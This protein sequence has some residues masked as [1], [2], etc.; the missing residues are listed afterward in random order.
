MLVGK[1]CNMSTVH[2]NVSAK[3]CNVSIEPVVLVLNSVM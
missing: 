2:C 3:H 1:L